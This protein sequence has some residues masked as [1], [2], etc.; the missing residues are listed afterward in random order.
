MF[1]LPSQSYSIYYTKSNPPESTSNSNAS[2]HTKTNEKTKTKAVVNFLTHQELVKLSNRHSNQNQSVYEALPISK[3]YIGYINQTSASTINL[4]PDSTAARNLTDAAITTTPAPTTPKWRNSAYQLTKTNQHHHGA[5]LDDKI[6]ELDRNDEHLDIPTI[7]ARMGYELEVE[8]PEVK[9]D[10]NI[11]PPISIIELTPQSTSTSTSAHG[12]NGQSSKLKT[13]PMG[14]INLQVNP[15]NPNPHQLVLHQKVTHQKDTFQIS[16]RNSSFENVKNN[17]PNHFQLSA[18]SLTSKSKPSV[19]KLRYR[20][21]Q[22]HLHQ[23]TLNNE[24]HANFNSPLNP[25]FC[26]PIINNDYDCESSN[27]SKRQMLRFHNPRY[28]ITSLLSDNHHH[29]LTQPNPQSQF[30]I[31]PTIEIPSGGF[32]PNQNPSRITNKILN[33][34]SNNSNF[35]M[36]TIS[37]DLKR[38]KPLSNMLIYS[39]LS[40]H[41]KHLGTG[42]VLIEIDAVAL[43]AWDLALTQSKVSSYKV[44][45]NNQPQDRILNKSI[46]DFNQSSNE[47]QALES[48]PSLKSKPSNPTLNSNFN[49]F[50]PGRS[51][52][53]K[54]LEVGLGVKRLK[55]GDLVYGLQDLKK[56]GAL[57][58]RMVI[59]KDLVAIAP[60]HPNLSMEQ[61]ACLPTLGVPSYFVMSTICA[62]LPKGSK[63]L[64]LNGHKGLG[65]MMCELVKYFRPNRD[66]W[67][68]CH[69]PTVATSVEEIGITVGRCEFRGA[70]EV[71]VEDSIL[72]SLN[73]I[74]ES[75]YDV[76][77]DTIGGR[78]IYDASRRIL[79]HE[80]MFISCVGDRLRM[81]NLKDKVKTN[82]RSLRRTFIKKDQK[83]I[84]YWCLSP[85]TEYDGQ[86]QTIREG[87]DELRKI[88]EDDDDC[89][90]GRFEDDL[91]PHEIAG[92][93]S[94]VK[95]D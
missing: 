4:L 89:F 24:D 20:S 30:R 37:L 48:N 52:V 60:V 67:V 34:N 78:R 86:R 84:G 59:D 68:T 55:K 27:H 21:N 40:N 64:I 9:P 10:H 42:Q 8:E 51:F 1:D 26:N 80:G 76:V 3:S 25:R 38:K 6:T 13:E 12:E 17:S 53:G 74:H 56:S 11:F 92:I 72:S 19:S 22:T 58:Q 81:K 88:I 91:Q 73:S 75:S 39:N 2:I 63:I 90:N 15:N 83:K 85:E 71:M 77:I 57:A 31:L 49:Q 93:D 16:F 95:M 44:S 82:F 29:Q 23:Q 7:V 70:R 62:G 46:H 45:S 47:Y 35:N 28:S 61:I 54:V 79:H 65:A 14:S 41:P 50:V 87:L 5:T 18:Q 69:I 36:F 32:V 66:L 43:D 33:P 94:E